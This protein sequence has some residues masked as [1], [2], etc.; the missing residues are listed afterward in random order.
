[1][2]LFFGSGLFVILVI[3]IWNQQ[4]QITQLRWEL[5]NAVREYEASQRDTAMYQKQLVDLQ[6]DVLQIWSDK[7]LKL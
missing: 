6:R 5:K 7:E 4:M 2:E 1:M 3:L